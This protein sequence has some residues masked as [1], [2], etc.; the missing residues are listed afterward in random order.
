MI[1][2]L[3][4]DWVDGGKVE[5]AMR[6]VEVLETLEGALRFPFPI[7]S[8]T[9]SIDATGMTS[10]VNVVMIAMKSASRV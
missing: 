1:Q 5:R 9:Y 7:F 4:L 8:V 6:R 3:F 2:S 10:C